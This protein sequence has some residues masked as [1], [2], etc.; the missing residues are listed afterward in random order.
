MLV[1]SHVAELQRRSQQTELH[2]NL[3]LVSTPHT[4][5]SFKNLCRSYYR[6]MSVGAHICMESQALKGANE[7]Q[8]ISLPSTMPTGSKS[9]TIL[10]SLTAASSASSFKRA[11]FPDVNSWRT[12]CSRRGVMFS[13]STHAVAR[14]TLS[15]G[16]KFRVGISRWK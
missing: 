3:H 16:D 12:A 9:L 1:Y 15:T 13:S 14:L 7:G 2:V 6:A 11:S 5:F 4:K 8:E 10:R